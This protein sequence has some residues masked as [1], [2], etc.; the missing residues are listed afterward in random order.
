MSLHKLQHGDA[1]FAD[2]RERRDFNYVISDFRINFGDTNI[3]Q[4]TRLWVKLM[5]AEGRSR[6][7]LQCISCLLYR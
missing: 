4:M 1:H 3:M 7:A 2:F 5:H 6:S